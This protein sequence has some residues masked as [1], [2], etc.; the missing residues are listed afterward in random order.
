MKTSARFLAM[1]LAVLMIAGAAMTVSAA[2]FSDIKEGYEHTAAIA[3]LA[4]LGVIDGYEDGTFRP[5]APVRRNEMAKLVYVLYTTFKNAGAGNVKF[6]DVPAGNWATGFISW[7]A[8]KNIVRGY[9]DGNFK[10]DNNVT[11]DEAL[12]MV[13]SVLGYSDFDSSVWPVDVRQKGIKDLKL[14]EGLED[15]NGSD[16]LTRGQVAQLLFNALDKPMKETKIVYYKDKNAAY[17]DEDGNSVDVWE[18]KEVAKTLAADVWNYEEVIYRVVGT[19]NYTYDEGAG[20]TAVL[21][22]E[23]TLK[24]VAVVDGTPATTV[25]EKDLEDLGLEAYEDNTDALIGLNIMTLTKDDE[26]LANASVIG[27][28]AVADVAIAGV[29]KDGVPYLDEVKI[30]GEVYKDAGKVK[31]FTNLKKLVYGASKVEAKDA[32]GPFVADGKTIDLSY[33]HTAVVMDNDGDGVFDAVAVG[34]YAPYVVTKVENKKATSKVPAH[35]VYTYEQLDGKNSTTIKSTDIADGKAL[36]EDDVFVAAKIGE[37]MYIDEVVA[38]VNAAATK[39][40]SGEKAAITLEGVGEVRYTEA[41]KKFF[42]GVAETNDLYAAAKDLL[43]DGEDGK[44][45]T[46]DYYIYNGRVIYATGVEAKSDSYDL[47]ILLYT[48][49]KGDMVIVDG[50]AQQNIPAVLL[51]DGKQVTV[52]VEKIEVGGNT[53]TAA[54]WDNAGNSPLEIKVVGDGEPEFHNLLVSYTVDKKTGKYTLTDKADAEITETLVVAKGAEF[55]YHAGT[56]FFNIGGK[57]VVLD[58]NSVIYALFAEEDKVAL[59]LNSYT[60]ATVITKFEQIYTAQNTYLLDNGPDD[61][62][63][64]LIA[65]VLDGELI[66][67]KGEVKRTY[68]NDARLIKYSVKAS[69]AEVVDG[70][71]Y[72]SYAFLNMDKM[73]NEALTIDTRTE[74]NDGAISA[75][76]GV[77]YGWNDAKEVYEKVSAA[78]DG[79]ESVTVGKLTSVNAKYGF[80]TIDKDITMTGATE[81]LKLSEGATLNSDVKIWSTFED[82]EEVYV[83]FDIASLAELVEEAKEEGK[84][85]NCAV[86]TYVDEDDNIQ[87]AWIIVDNYYDKT[88]KEG[89]VTYTQTYDVVGKIK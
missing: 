26:P 84:E 60:A 46:Q 25:E 23:D 87:I 76:L 1:L 70:K 57:N 72:Y 21:G 47:A 6:N 79:M 4:Q 13:C 71:A 48:E 80:V 69:A 32:F 22:D 65:T 89:N 7:C 58:D 56:R 54:D 27:T 73:E 10:P 16:K 43:A 78:A 55:K 68:K 42:K 36:E 45:V 19:E 31:N 33:P 9:G 85:I 11:Y 74:I 44:P 12:T 81:A 83:T 30:N 34:F 67:D 38:P 41:G 82:D 64:T 59:E 75:D 24:V 66:A 51:I 20:Y 8:A 40:T 17:E 49:K 15:V 14:G 63:Y 28:V 35:V 3:T 86:G 18:P 88:D 52:N 29:E 61:D 62:T 5:D 39:V 2:S 50:K 37:T 77:F 53:Y